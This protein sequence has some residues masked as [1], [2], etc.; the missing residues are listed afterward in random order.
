MESLEIEV[1]VN[2]AYIQRVSAGQP[3]TATLDA[4]PDWKIPAE[5]IAIV[6]TADRQKATV[7]VRIGFVERDERVL[8]DMGVKVAFL[9]D[10]SQ[11]E[12]S[13]QV[14]RVV[15]IPTAALNTDSGGN[16]VWI[17]RDETAVRREIRVGE[18]SSRGVQ[19]MSGVASGDRVVTEARAPLESGARIAVL[20]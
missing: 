7:R 9:E 10:S 14:K 12:D 4:Y 6:P 8:R 16:F 2:E 17:V 13:L 11:T 15:Y 20:K 19:V 18:R 5:V 1:D 3:V